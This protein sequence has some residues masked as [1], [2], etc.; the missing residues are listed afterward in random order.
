MG[1][2]RGSAQLLRDELNNS[3]QKEYLDVVVNEADR[4]N[5]MLSQILN[6]AGS[7]KLHSEKTNIH[8]ILEDIITLEKKKVASKKGRF[9]QD[10]D[11]SLPLIDA[12]EDKLKQV[13]INLIQNAIEAPLDFQCGGACGLQAQGSAVARQDQVRLHGGGEKAWGGG[14]RRLG[15]HPP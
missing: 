8:K 11:P 15:A 3:E 12:D 7:Q 9:I 13:F 10:Y 4:I 14:R 2:I 1:G 6:L 5:R